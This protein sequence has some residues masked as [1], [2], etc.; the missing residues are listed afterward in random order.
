MTSCGIRTT[1]QSDAV[2]LHAP[3][4]HTTLMLCISTG[5]PI[6]E[7]GNPQRSRVPFYVTATSWGGSSCRIKVHPNL[8][9]IIAL[10]DKSFRLLT[11]SSRKAPLVWHTD[12]RAHHNQRDERYRH[13]ASEHRV[14]RSLFKSP[15]SIVVEARRSSPSLLRPN[16]SNEL[17][18]KMAFPS[19]TYLVP[20]LAGSGTRLLPPALLHEL[21]SQACRPSLSSRMIADFT[22]CYFDSS[23]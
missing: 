13:S 12:V 3:L 10:A 11:N 5:M 7:T 6:P 15:E 21:A 1:A 23:P 18:E 17:S 22:A 8:F 14:E 4:E 9:P 2:V 16:P 19:L 20:Y